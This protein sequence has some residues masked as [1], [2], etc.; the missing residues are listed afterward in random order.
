M[1]ILNFWPHPERQ[2]REAQVIALGFIEEAVRQGKKYIILEAPVGAG[3]S[4]IGVTASRYLSGGA[5]NGYILTPQRILQEQYRQEFANVGVVPFYGKSNYQCP[6]KGVT[7]DIGGLL[8]PKCMPCVHKQ[9]KKAAQEAPNVVMN[10]KLALLSFTV[11]MAFSPSQPRKLMVLDEAHALEDHL[12]EFD[13]VSVTEWRC[14]KINLPWE[15]QSDIT[16]AHSWI[17]N[18]YLPALEIK[19]GTMVREVERIRAKKRDDM[20]REDINLLREYNGLLD[21]INEITVYAEMEIDEL[22]K[23]HILVFDK[24]K[25][26]IKPLYARKNFHEILAPMAETIL[27]M[28]STLYG[29]EITCRKYGI[30][31]DDAAYLSLDSEFPPENRPVIYKPVCK[32]NAKW[33]E[34]ENSGGRERMLTTIRQILSVHD[35]VSGI[36]HTGNFAIAQWLVENLHG[37][38]DHELFH[39]NP[40]CGMNRNDVIGNFMEYPTPSVL[41]SPSCTE[42]LDLKDDLSRFAVFIKTPFP[43]LGDQWVHRRM[44]LDEVWYQEKAMTAV[45][46]GGGRVVRSKTDHGI[47]Y[48]LDESFGFLMYRFGRYVPHWWKIAYHKM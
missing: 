41:I 39:H 45:I 21:H 48:V 12:V 32:M 37:T 16:R 36:I 27:F 20:T 2:P 34:E 1:N 7:C 9:A 4:Y 47:T 23:E 26:D 18:S 11:G 5:G 25:F 30:N 29:K 10:Y 31:P 14:K 24:T 44:E 40:N 6:S 43:N 3:K 17:K 28:S 13:T 15:P 42:G 33:A 8:T 22:L 38:V 35:K 46:Q 19:E